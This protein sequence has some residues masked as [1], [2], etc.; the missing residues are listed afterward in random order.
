M[1]VNSFRHN[2]YI[3]AILACALGVSACDWRSPA[4]DS[5]ALEDSIASKAF[6]TAEF[7]DSVKINDAIAYQ[8]IRVD[9]PAEDDSSHVA[10]AALEWLCCEV[11]S[12]CYPDYIGVKIDSAFAVGDEHTT[13][14][15]N[16][17][18]TYGHKGLQRMTADL[19]EFAEDGFEGFMA[20]DLA[21]ELVENRPEYITY[22]LEHD[23]YTGG[24]HGAQYHKGLTFRTSDGATF[25]W[26]L[27]DSSKRAELIQLLK[28]GLM[29]YFNQGAEEPI[30]TDS[31]LFEMLLLFD[32]PDTQENELEFGLPLPATD[33]W[34]T[35]DG[36]VFI[37][38]EYEIAAYAFGRPMV[39]LPFS[40]VA[41]CLTEAGRK[42]ISFD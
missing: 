16:V 17:V 40:V 7:S 26:N 6:C 42:F 22:T 32:D 24:A 4:T 10:Q 14:A 27:F 21:I 19:K 1:T 34:I 36:I 15:E 38:Q 35:S 29:A 2:T 25:N 11:R 5:D 39:T 9:F 18:D 37:Y 31:A 3:L 13:F 30:C 23:V 12:R 28:N 33:P 41:P 8:N 20:N